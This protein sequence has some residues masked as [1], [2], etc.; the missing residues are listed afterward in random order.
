V[1][2]GG[3]TPS[4][5][6]NFYFGGEFKVSV[7]F[8]FSFLGDGPIKMTCCIPKKKKKKKKLAKHPPSNEFKREYI[9]RI[10]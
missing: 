8:F 3:G 7:V 2:Q 1:G 10:W 4:T 6:R 5:N 9:T